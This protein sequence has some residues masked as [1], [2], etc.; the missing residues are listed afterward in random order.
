MNRTESIL[1][2]MLKE[3]TGKHM[4]DSGGIY[5]RHWQ[6]NQTRDFDH[7]PAVFLEFRVW[8][9]SLEID[10]TRNVYQFLAEQLDYNPEIDAD[11]QEFLEN[12]DYIDFEAMQEYCDLN[13]YESNI[14]NTY[15]GECNLSQTLQFITFG[16]GPDLYNQEHVLLQVHGGCDVR[17]GYST[18]RAFDLNYE[19]GLYMV[20]DGSIS[21]PECGMYWQTDDTY[22]WYA[23]GSCGFNAG[24]EL[25]EYDAVEGTRGKRGKVVVNEDG[26]AFC[27]CCGKGKL[28]A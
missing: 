7:E 25:Q 21:C 26:E 16:D 17:G 12:N 13:G 23:E 15:N 9:D 1:N 22:H 24:T 14:V 5:G 19:C 3:D 27:P 2:S 8:K 18:P 4:L 11:F 20:T 6:R 10:Y 28:E